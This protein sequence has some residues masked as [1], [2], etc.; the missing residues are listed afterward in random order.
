MQALRVIPHHEMAE[1]MGDLKYLGTGDL[2]KRWGYTVRGVRILATNELDFPKP[3]FAVNGGRIRVWEIG[4]IQIWESAHPE[5]RSSEAKAHKSLYGAAFRKR[6][7]LPYSRVMHPP[8]NG[9]K[10]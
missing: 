7:N 3:A 2:A 4:A 5:T 6:N 10:K 1:I 8:Q 9:V